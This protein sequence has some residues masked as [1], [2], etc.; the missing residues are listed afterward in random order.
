[1]GLGTA[2]SKSSRGDRCTGPAVPVSLSLAVR[3]E[4]TGGTEMHLD[5]YVAPSLCRAWAAR[6]NEMGDG[7]QCGGPE[8][9][10]Y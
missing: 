2:E 10:A 3:A 4:V 6:G 8:F 5:G 9:M 7:A 1:M